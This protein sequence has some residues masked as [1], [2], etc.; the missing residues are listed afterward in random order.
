VVRTRFDPLKFADEIRR[1]VWQLNP[2]QPTKISTLEAQVADFTAE[3]RFSMLL[4]SAFAAIA[5]VLATVGIYSVTS[6]W[7]LQRTN[8]IG[9]RMAMGANAADVLH[10]VLRQS[11][12]R[13]SHQ[14]TCQAFSGS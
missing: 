10:M 9:I 5:L 6:Q 12:A 1:K 13:I 3:P 7:V 4:L 11:L 8:E 2:N 14:W